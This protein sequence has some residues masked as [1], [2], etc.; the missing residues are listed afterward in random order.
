MIGAARGGRREFSASRENGAEEAQ[1][2]CS[3]SVL[4]SSGP[5]QQVQA[6]WR[7]FP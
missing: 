6:E 1:L 3:G 2:P 4:A 5:A 7:R